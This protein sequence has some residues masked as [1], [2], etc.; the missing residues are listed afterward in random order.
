MSV[1]VKLSLLSAGGLVFA[2]THVSPACFAESE[3]IYIKPKQTQVSTTQPKITG[4]YE[5]LVDLQRDAVKQAVIKAKAATQEMQKIRSAIKKYE[6]EAELKRQQEAA[7]VQLAPSAVAPERSVSLRSLEEGEMP[8][9]GEK[10]K[11]VEEQTAPQSA[12]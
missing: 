4:N 7:P 3:T 10:E 9:D 2:L 8:E 5:Q 12:D 1:Q 11:E 6:A